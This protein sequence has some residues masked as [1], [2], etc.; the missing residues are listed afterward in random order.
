VYPTLEYHNTLDLWTPGEASNKNIL[1]LRTGDYGLYGGVLTLLWRE[2]FSLRL[3]NGFCFKANFWNYKSKYDTIGSIC[4]QRKNFKVGP[5]LLDQQK[6]S[7]NHV[8]C[9]QISKVN[10]NSF[11]YSHDESYNSCASSSFVSG[12]IW[13]LECYCGMRTISSIFNLLTSLTILSVFELDDNK[14]LNKQI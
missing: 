7:A 4:K 2:S 11:S 1:P 13:K 12:L 3:A 10:W 6:R 9:P 8:E 14:Y 5:L